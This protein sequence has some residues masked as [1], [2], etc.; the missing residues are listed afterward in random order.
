MPGYSGA[1]LQVVAAPDVQLP[2]K[3]AASIH[4]KSLTWAHWNADLERAAFTLS[5]AD[6]QVIRTNIVEVV[7]HSPPLIRSQL[8]LCL[9]NIVSSD[10][11]N[12]WPEL[13]PKVISLLASRDAASTLGALEVLHV[14]VGKY[15]YIPAGKKRRQPLQAV[16]E[17]TFPIVL[18]LFQNLGNVQTVESHRMQHVIIRIFN[19]AC[20]LGVPPHL[21]NQA[22]F[23]PWMNALLQA[24]QRP[25]PEGQPED[26]DVRKRWPFWKCKKWAAR[27]FT[28]LFQRYG[29]PSNVD[30]PA[31]KAFSIAFY[32]TYSV[33]LLEAFLTVLSERRGGGGYLPDKLCQ[34]ALQYIDQAVRARNTYTALKPH[35]DA[36]FREIIFPLICLTEDDLELWESD[37]QE[38][39]RRESDVV[40]EYYNPHSEA[41]NIVVDIVSLRGKNHLAQLMHYIVSILMRYVQ[42]PPEQ[43]NYREKDGALQVIG[44]LSGPLLKRKEYAGSLEQMMVVHVL[45]EFQNPNGYLRSRAC[46][47]FS[48]YYEIDYENP[49]NF[50]AGLAA[51]VTC[52]RDPELPVRVQ[53]GLAMRNLVRA[54][55]AKAELQKVLPEL[56]QEFLKM[57]NEVEHD[58]LVSSLEG[59]IDEFKDSMAPYALSLCSQL[60]GVFMRA[61]TSGDEESETSAV[62]ACECLNTIMTLLGGIKDRQDLWDQLEV[63]LLPLLH[64]IASGD[65]MDYFDDGLKILTYITYYSQTISP[66][67]W[68]LFPLLCQAFDKFAFDFL[69]DLMYPLDNYISRGTETFLTGNHLEMILNIF[70]KVY[71]YEHADFEAIRDGTELVQVVLQACRG[72]VDPV[73]DV[74]LSLAV[75]KLG[76]AKDNDEKVILIE[77]VA[78]C[79]YY[80]PHLTLKLLESRNWLQDIFALWMMLQ[81]DFTK[82]RTKKIVLL[83]LTSLFT[84][85]TD[86]LPAVIRMNLKPILSTVLAVEKE[87]IA[88]HEE[89]DEESEE[90]EDHEAA[91]IDE[92]DEAKEELLLSEFKET[93]K[94]AQSMHHHADM[95]DQSD[96]D[97]A[98]FGV[99]DDD[100][101]E[102]SSALDGIDELIYF[103]EQFKIFGQREP[104]LYRD[105]TSDFTVQAELHHLDVKA[106]ERRQELEEQQR[107]EE[108]EKQQRQQ[109][110]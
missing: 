91:E 110:R 76:N 64:K 45:P 54:E 22:V 93:L 95:D 61:A 98:G 32:E 24:L 49:A 104:A 16:V 67:V 11:P 53:A 57:M 9:E 69:N 31:D 26:L 100:D 84:I 17:A 68:Q 80:N 1:L 77:L 10:Y 92:E 109:Q 102:I 38:Y 70:R 94:Q 108:L 63:V 75:P 44:H 87:A 12:A 62:T 28:R 33:R 101:G 13:L 99:A 73:V 6:K 25:V 27:A 40:E 85:P 18:Q 83:A 59:L 19:S 29:D 65:L 81:K 35:F 37:P 96:D 20:N 88:F 21:L 90:E 2:L 7:I 8:V 3:Q 55:L 56:L 41:L 58:E 82:F 4:L 106:T 78:N 5:D 48:E 47:I 51:T 107:E 86:T 72:R 15:E 79:I 103:V 71:T 30:A 43:R 89:E 34:Q 36:F 50:L 39:I 46:W 74:A 105:L 14:I 66:Q 23:M 52:M 42:S 97:F 60:V